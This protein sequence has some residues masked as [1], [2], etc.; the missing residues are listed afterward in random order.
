MLG[1]VNELVGLGEKKVISGFELRCLLCLMLSVLAYVEVVPQFG[2]D[3]G[4][5][6]QL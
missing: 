5:R 6:G 4:D 1:L 3:E 2:G